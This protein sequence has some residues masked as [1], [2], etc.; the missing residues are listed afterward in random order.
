[1]SRVLDFYYART[2]QRIRRLRA[3]RK[4]RELRP[5]RD[6][7][8]RIAGSD[9]LLFCTVHNEAA[10]LP[11]F[12]DYYR[13]LGVG[14]FLFIDN[15]STDGTGDYLAQQFDVSLWRASTSY[16]RANFGMDWVNDLLRRHGR[17]HWCLTVDADEFLVYPHQDTRPLKALT[18]WLDA[19][20][21]RALGCL[22]LDMYPDRDTAGFDGGNP[23]AYLTHFDAN[24]YSAARNGRFGNIWI[25]G[26][27]RRRRYFAEA[28]EQAPALNK[29]PLVKWRRG[30]IYVSSTHMLLP[31]RL[32][33]TYETKGGEAIS[34]VLMHAKFLPDLASKAEAEARRNQHFAAGREYAAYRADSAYADLC[35]P[36]S[37]RYRNWRQ[38]EELGLMSHGGWV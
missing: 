10:R 17:G 30:D 13:K 5:V 23:F 29:I 14:H 24:N 6:R 16:R 37:A 21:L 11:Y 32:N 1:M 9:I 26:G 38:L 36:D 28:P 3:L 20:N 34:G 4:G 15:A 27:P 18:D 2:L 35:T 7:T 25:Q 33:R 19:S 12:L 31:R 22:L 8:E